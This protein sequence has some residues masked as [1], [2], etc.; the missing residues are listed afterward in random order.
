MNPVSRSVSTALITGG[1]KGIGRAVS[2]ALA[3]SGADIA[4]L[5]KHD[6]AAG[7]RLVAEIRQTGR[8]AQ[9]FYGDIGNRRQVNTLLSTM[10][11]QFGS[12]DMLVNNAGANAAGALL[13]LDDDAWE[14]VVATNLTGCFVVG[15][16]VAKIMRAQG[17]GSIVNIAGASAH[18]CYPGAG[19]F[20]PSKAAVV[21]L[22]RQM[23]IEWADYGIRVNGVSPGPIR[24]AGENWQ[25]REPQLAAEV[26]RLPLRRAGLP[27]DVAAAVSYLLSPGAA[28][29]TGQMLVVD[30]GG[31]CTWY[32]TR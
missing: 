4:L 30:G 16:E 19:A 17:G 20:G 7:E 5:I 26:A 14:R 27:E 21:N 22:T 32:M 10:V 28:Y 15:T 9:V 18:R 24:P 25:T 29:V 13:D 3:Q 23:A 12:I 2:L 31:L 6:R 11:A 8:R 1:S